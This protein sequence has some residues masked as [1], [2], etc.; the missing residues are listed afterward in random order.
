MIDIQEQITQFQNILQNP[1]IQQEHI[2]NA[3]FPTPPN[4][5]SIKIKHGIPSFIPC[6]QYLYNSHSFF[7][8]TIPTFYLIF[9]HNTTIIQM[10]HLNLQK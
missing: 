8:T 7:Q 3:L 4:N 2:Q 6:T 1:N 9:Y 10:A 5:P